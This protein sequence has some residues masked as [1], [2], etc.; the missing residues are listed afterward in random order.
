MRGRMA[1]ASVTYA[2]LTLLLKYQWN[3]FCIL[4]SDD[5]FGQGMAAKFQE[6]I[7]TEQPNLRFYDRYINFGS[8][9]NATYTDAKTNLQVITSFSRLD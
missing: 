3:K 1:D 7:R 2:F 8:D 5:I 9:T 4:G 6:I